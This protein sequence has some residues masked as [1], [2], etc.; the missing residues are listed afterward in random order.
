MAKKWR[1]DGIFAVKVDAENRQEA[2]KKAE[3]ILRDSGL[4]GCV[5]EAEEVKKDE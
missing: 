4:D 1:V 5:M 3:R 2:L